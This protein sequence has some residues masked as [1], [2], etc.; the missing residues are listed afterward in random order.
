[1]I[2]LLLPAVIGAIVVAAC[3][4]HARRVATIDRAVA[5][6]APDLDLAR[7]ELRLAVMLRRAGVDQPVGVVVRT[8]LLLVVAAGVVGAGLRPAFGVLAATSAVAA[9]PIVL[10]LARHRAERRA[11][12]SLPAMLR[13]VASELRIGGTMTTAL[14]TVAASPHPLARDTVRIRGRMDLGASLDEA[15][16][17]WIDERP[18]TGVRAAAGALTLAGSVGGPAA[19]AIDGLASSI[20]DRIAATAE[21]RAQSAQARA[22]AL[23][24]VLAPIGY[25]LFASTIDQRSLDVLLGTTFGR[26]C[27]G[28][29]LALDALAVV[30]IRFLVRAEPEA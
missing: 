21:T 22:S 13:L 19:D 3:V 18:I 1:V 16:A 8:W 9:G 11:A 26:A 4:R 10:L 7:R 30:W 28:I 23:V 12:Y 17:R 27:L 25:L 15:L 2:A 29:G 14:D 6:R 24:M 5:A 20:A